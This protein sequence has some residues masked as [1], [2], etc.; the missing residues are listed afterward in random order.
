MMSFP[1][2]DDKLLIYSMVAGVATAGS[3]PKRFFLS[4]PYVVE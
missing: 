1:L 3:F 2:C 4:Y